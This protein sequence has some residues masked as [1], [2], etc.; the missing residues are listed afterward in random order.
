M[1]DEKGVFRSVAAI[2][3]FLPDLRRAELAEFSQKITLAVGELRGFVH[4]P[5]VREKIAALVREMNSRLSA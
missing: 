1:S 2:E 3:P 4:A 5:V